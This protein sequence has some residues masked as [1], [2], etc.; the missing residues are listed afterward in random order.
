MSSEGPTAPRVGVGAVVFREGR[1]LLALRAKSP[2]KD[3]WAIPGGR[4]ELGETLE[5]A[6]ER[7]LLEETGVRA[8]AGEVV[9]TFQHIDR[10]DR[11]RVRHHYVILDL[12]AEFLSGDPVPGDDARDARWVA[13]AE[14]GRLPVNPGTRRLL[15]TCY[16]FGLARPVIRPLASEEREAAAGLIGR[17]FDRDVAQDCDPEGIY[18]FRIFSSAGTMALRAANRHWALVA[19]MDGAPA[20][21]VEV[22]EDR[23]IAMLFVDPAHQG[24]GIGRRLFEAAAARCRLRNPKLTRLTV[25]A[26][27]NAVPVYA[28]LGFRPDGPPTRECGIPHVPMSC[29]L[30]SE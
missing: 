16:G 21:V 18:N 26:S 11:G 8:R 10:D 29:R 15:R 22:R 13:E 28:R 1:V 27:P 14:I 3:Q 23:H 19:E 2:A 4:L 12:A 9:F 5:E 24:A 20:G 25:A 7:E 17:A 6:A 30:P